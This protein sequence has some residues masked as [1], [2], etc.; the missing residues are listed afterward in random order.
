MK[1]LKNEAVVAELVR[2]AEANGG[3]LQPAAVVEAARAEDSPL[4]SQFEWDDS[5][6]SASWRLHQARQ[7][8][9]VVVRY[10]KVADDKMVPC[11][12]FV[13]L[14]TDRKEEGGGY[15]LT[16]DVLS[17][18]GQRHQF[19]LD[20][21]NDLRRVQR[22]YADIKELAAVFAEVDNV[23]ATMEESLRATA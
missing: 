21:L 2:L 23:E 13:S 18:T 6:A 17:D 16:T 3:E 4:H 7:L 11:R 22:K 15:R 20:A 5:A 1:M 12:V 8:I 19:L 10:E 9:N 14:T